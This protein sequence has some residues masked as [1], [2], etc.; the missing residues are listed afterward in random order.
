MSVDF[1]LISLDSRTVALPIG[2]PDLYDMY[3]KSTECFWV[4][5]EIT[6]EA[7]AQQFPTLHKAI[8]QGVTTIIGWFA[9]SDGRVVTNL[10]ERFIK[11]IPIYEVTRFFNF[12]NAMEDIHA[13]TYARN[14]E[15]IIP[16]KTTRDK[17]FAAI[18]T[19]PIIKRM[20]DY[21]DSATISSDKLSARL[22][23]FACVEGIWFTGCFAFI[24]WLGEQNLMPGMVHANRLISRDEGLHTDFGLK[25]ITM[26][27][28]GRNLTGE[29]AHYYIREAVSI[30]ID[31][32]NEMLPKQEL[33]G[34]NANF[35]TQHIQSKADDMLMKI[36]HKVIW[37]VPSPFT[38][39]N[40][41]G[42]PG[43]TGFFEHRV[44]DY[45]KTSA[46]TADNELDMDV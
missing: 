3:K 11:E 44:A 16:D 7:D 2:R 9:S 8:R 12:Q 21:V 25:L 34:M 29:E 19:M 22:L 46:A 38:F 39:S 26:I 24:D 27:K 31:F 23:R 45:A 33:I 32:I 13:H 15:E 1:D 10:S 37:N 28:P 42:I 35:M 20:N 40:L 5:D 18:D 4:T 17:L 41:R 43:K 36:R 30:G 6:F 14:I